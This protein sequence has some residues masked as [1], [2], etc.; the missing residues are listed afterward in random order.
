MGISHGLFGDAASYA[1]ARDLGLTSLQ[2]VEKGIGYK[3]DAATLAQRLLGS[4]QG[5]QPPVYDPGAV[6]GAN[7]SVLGGASTVSPTAAMETSANIAIANSEAAWSAKLSA[8]N[9]AMSMYTADQNAEIAAAQLAAA[10]KQSEMAMWGQIIGGGAQ[11]VSAAAVTKI[12]R[13]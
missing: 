2:I 11:G 7:L 4:A 3:T 12:M 6:Y 10:K 1:T 8:A 13:P 9:M 5:I